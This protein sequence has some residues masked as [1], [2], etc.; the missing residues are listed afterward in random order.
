MGTSAAESFP[1]SAPA[2]S[3]VVLLV[4]STLFFPREE[5]ALDC[6]IDKGK[7]DLVRQM[8]LRTANWGATN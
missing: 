6:Q 2:S 4:A 7:V 1:S 8:E 3:R 5:P